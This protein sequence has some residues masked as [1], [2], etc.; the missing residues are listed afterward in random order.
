MHFSV[1]RPY[2]RPVLAMIGVL[3]RGLAWASRDAVIVETIA[4]RQRLLAPRR[5]AMRSNLWSRDR[6]FWV[7]MA[8]MWSAGYGRG[9]RRHDQMRRHIV[10]TT[11]PRACPSST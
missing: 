8:Q 2:D 9:S 11:F 3:L 4:L 7:V 10:T 6:L 1:A 5:T